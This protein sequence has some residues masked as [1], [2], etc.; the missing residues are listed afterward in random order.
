VLA[1]SS[2]AKKKRELKNQ[3]ENTQPG[4]YKPLAAPLGN[5]LLKKRKEPSK[6]KKMQPKNQK[7]S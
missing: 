7:N 6:C 2:P 1:T 4:V 3:H 5:P